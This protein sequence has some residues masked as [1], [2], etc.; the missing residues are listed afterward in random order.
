MDELTVFFRSNFQIAN[1]INQDGNA[2]FLAG[3]CANY[4]T[5]QIMMNHRILI[6]LITTALLSGC[7]TPMKVLDY[8]DMPSDALVRVGGITVLTEQEAADDKYA[9]LGVATGFSCRRD[10]RAKMLAED[11]ITNRNAFDQLILSAADLGADFV[12]TP[13]CT[14]REGIDLSNNCTDSL[15]CTAQ[16][17]AVKTE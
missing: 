5:V 6:V 10:P 9:T 2:G 4:D 14:V 7:G 8:Y 11:S 3:L 12:S 13:K 1:I 15:T 16:A 17:F